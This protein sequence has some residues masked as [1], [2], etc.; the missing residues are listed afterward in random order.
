MVGNVANTKQL[1]LQ[2]FHGSAIGGHLGILVATQRLTRVY[3]KGLRKDV[4]EF[5]QKYSTCQHY[6]IGNVDTLGLLQPLFIPKGVF[7]DITMDSVEALPRSHGK[8]V[9]T[10]IVDQFTKYGYFIG[11]SHPYA[12][13][14]VA[15]NF[16]DSIYNIHGLLNTITSD[17]GSI[18]VS[19]F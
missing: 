18:F 3:C 10:M 19:R 14:L 12:T 17:V 4:Q 11:L 6:K 8:V 1:L 2:H 9:I 13:Y 15:Q 7:T 5:I 16:L